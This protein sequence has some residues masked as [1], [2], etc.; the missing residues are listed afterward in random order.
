MAKLIPASPGMT[1]EKAFQAEPRLKQLCES[2]PRMARLMEV[3]KKVEGL[4]RHASTHAA[5]LVIS[6]KPLTEYVPLDAGKRR[7]PSHPIPDGRV[8]VDRP[9]EGGF[10]RA[11][12]PDGDRAGQRLIRETEGQGKSDFD[13][14]GYGG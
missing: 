12:Q 10:P 5:G 8:G 13:R 9:F 1:L 11:S 3:V 2:N 14:I 4:P 6:E 7:G